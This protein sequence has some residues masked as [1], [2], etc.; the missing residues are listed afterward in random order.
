MVGRVPCA[1]GVSACGGVASAS[2]RDLLFG[3]KKCVLPSTRNNAGGL[4]MQCEQREKRGAR[5]LGKRPNPHH[6]SSRPLSTCEAHTSPSD[7]TT[8]APCFTH[9]HTPIPVSSAAPRPPAPTCPAPPQQPGME[10][11]PQ[12]TG[13]RR[14]PGGHDAWISPRLAAKLLWMGHYVLEPTMLANASS[15]GTE[16]P[17]PLRVYS[18]DQDWW[19]RLTQCLGRLLRRLS[20]VSGPSVWG[21][22]EGVGSTGP[23]TAAQSR[24]RQ[25]QKE[26]TSPGSRLVDWRNAF[27]GPEQDI[28]GQGGRPGR[29]ISAAVAGVVVGS[30]C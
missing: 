2:Y 28:P 25:K 29:T 7:D 9:T 22:G 20:E 5:H 10:W 27:A 12:D 18:K 11:P 15:L 24:D 13:G 8:L 26:G 19:Q 23:A 30:A 1:S 17:L 4:E 3:E 14:R 21:G 16:L 6:P